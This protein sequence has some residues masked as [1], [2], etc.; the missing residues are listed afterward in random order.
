V[1][2][3]DWVV[4]CTAVFNSLV[5]AGTLF[6]GVAQYNRQRKHS[7]EDGKQANRSRLTEAYMAWHA[8]LLSS[9]ENIRIASSLIRR[10]YHVLGHGRSH[11]SLEQT[12]AVHLLYMLL[13]SLFLEWNYRN[14]YSPEEMSEL[15]R[16]IDHSLV[17]IINNPNPEF[18]DIVD[19]FE[20]V[21]DDF[22]VGF[23]VKISERIKELRDRSARSP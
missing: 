2:P 4:L 1:E 20:R 9:P 12:H 18:R 22:P 14:A 19:N 6:W 8:A 15:D 17:G 23:R 10:G 7:F 16:T 5:F 11:V 3:K 21:F 13:N